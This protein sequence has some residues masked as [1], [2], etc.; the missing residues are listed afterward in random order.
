MKKRKPAA[1]P[2][3]ADVPYSLE[4]E[5][6]V[7]GAVMVQGNDAFRR[8]S[9]I[10]TE[11]SFFFPAHRTVFGAMRRIA[12]RGAAQDPVTV[13][14]ALEGEQ[15]AATPA[16]VAG[17]I[18]GVPLSSN[19]EHYAG[20]LR[21]KSIRRQVMER[22]IDLSRS[23]MNGHQLADVLETGKELYRTAMAA[24]DET[25]RRC[26]PSSAVIEEAMQ[27]AKRPDGHRIRTHIPF[28]D[29]HIGGGIYPGEVLTI[30]ARPQVGKSAI[31][32]QMLLDAAR[33]NERAVFFSLEMPRHQAMMRMLQ[34]AFDLDEKMLRL[35]LARNCIGM[36]SAQTAQ[37]EVIKER[38]CIVDRAKSSIEHLD[39]AMTEACA[40]LEGSPRIVAIDYLGLLSSGSKNLPLY[41][42]VSEAAIDVKSFAKR[43]QV[44]VL[45]LSQ[46]ARDQNQAVSE[47]AGRLGLDAARDSGQVEEAADFVVT[48]WRPGLSSTSREAGEVDRHIECSMVKNRRG[49]LG[50]FTLQIDLETTRVYADA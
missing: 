11:E 36:T 2:T 38:V 14:A 47:G 34:Q 7:L 13:N 48:M 49:R 1:L 31:A 46:A 24:D 43:H 8:A 50:D 35:L 42:R 4:A 26:S 45:L 23:C 29:R 25:R 37:M 15:D 5:R 40:V 19:L 9:A 20:I 3:P 30:I 10:L 41:Q 32:S 12:A 44:A 28:L 22:A 39:G 16:E 17:L 21:E 6:A 27:E 18:D 33:S